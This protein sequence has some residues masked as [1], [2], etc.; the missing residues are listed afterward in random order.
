MGSVR[1]CRAVDQATTASTPIAGIICYPFGDRPILPPW[2]AWLLLLLPAAHGSLQANH[3][4]TPRLRLSPR[5][6]PEGPPP[7]PSA[8]LCPI[9]CLGGPIGPLLAVTTELAADRRGKATA[10]AMITPLVFVRFAFR[11]LHLGACRCLGIACIQRG[12]DNYG[13]LAGSALRSIH[14]VMPGRFFDKS[15]VISFKCARLGIDF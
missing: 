8:H 11:R 14:S 2:V 12:D 9:P 13:R 15:Q 10:R 1:L 5:S 3:R 4:A 6:G 7:A